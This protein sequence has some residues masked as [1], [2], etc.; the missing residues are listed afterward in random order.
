MSCTAGD[1]YPRLSPRRRPWLLAAVAASALLRPGVTRAEPVSVQH[2]EGLVHGFLALRTLDG[3]LIADGDLIQNAHDDQVTS[4][5]VFRFKDGSI[6]DETAVF[7]QRQHFRLL[8][9][10]LVQ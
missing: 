2:A 5:L 7:S 3:T 6:R 9:N 10:H 1:A 8:R 4:R